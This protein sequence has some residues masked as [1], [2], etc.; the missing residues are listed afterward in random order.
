MKVIKGICNGIDK[1]N[2][3]LGRVFSVLVLGILGVILCEV[4]LGV[5]STVPRSG[6]RI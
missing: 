6:P 5:F 2:D 1:F 3:I 4:V